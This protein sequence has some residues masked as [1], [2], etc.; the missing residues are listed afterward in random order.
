MSLESLTRSTWATRSRR[1]PSQRVKAAMRIA[2]C[3]RGNH[4]IFAGQDAE[5]LKRKF[6]LADAQL[7]I[8]PCLPRSWPKLLRPIETLMRTIRAESFETPLTPSCW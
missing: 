1:G 7:V 2:R 4:P 5:I 8:A 6:A 3:I